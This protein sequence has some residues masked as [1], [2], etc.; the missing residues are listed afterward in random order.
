M[1][2]FAQLLMSAALL[3]GANA[4]PAFAACEIPPSLNPCKTCHVLEPGKPSRATGPNLQ[5][6]AGQPAMHSADFA[7]YSEAMKAAQAKGLTWTD[8]SLFAYIA[9]PK[10]FLNTF[11]GQP[12]K[13]GMM[14]QLKDEAK[15]KAAIEGLKTI[16]ACQ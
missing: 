11:N 6:V 15:R 12:L 10:G 13:N 3:S 14:F 16:A 2:K 8:E 9:D 7:K 4:L 5:G 1:N